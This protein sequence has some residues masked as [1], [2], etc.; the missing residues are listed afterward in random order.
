MRLPACKPK[1]L[2][3]TVL[4][5]C[6]AISQTTGRRNSSVPEPQR[7]RLGIGIFLITPANASA[8]T[9]LKALPACVC[10]TT[11]HSPLGVSTVVISSTVTPAERIKPSS[12]LVG[13]PSLKAAALA[14][15]RRSTS[16][17]GCCS[18]TL[19]KRA[20]MRRGVA[21]IS[22]CVEH[23]SLCFNA[24]YSALPKCLAIGMTD[25]AG[26]S[27]QPSSISRSAIDTGLRISSCII[28]FQ[29]RE[30][31]FFTFA[32]PCLSDLAR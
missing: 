4:A 14:G 5:P 19:I 17:S 25:A 31:Q 23:S 20:A 2:N 12:A 7:M 29:Q 22:G 8:S 26:N 11:I 18:P 9:S 16:V 32:Q 24:V 28:V 30:P 3:G 13:W 6:T 21:K 1:T 27:S 10:F 15:P